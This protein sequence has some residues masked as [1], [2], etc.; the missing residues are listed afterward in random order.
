VHQ[1]PDT[2]DPYG[3][4]TDAERTLGTLGVKSDITRLSGR[5]TVKGGVDLVMLRPREDL[6]YLSQPWIDFTHLPEVN[7]THVHFRGPNLGPGVP[8]PVIF[9]D[10]ETGGQASAFVQDKVQVTSNLTVD[11]GVRFDHYSLAFT[12]SHVSPRV[13]AAYRCHRAPCCSGRT[14][15]STCRRRSKTCWPAAP[16]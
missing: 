7:E 16:A 6:Y 13:N 4:Q 11:L 14:T 15:I 8:R 1:F 2:I 3:A 9:N 12:E 10:K 5:H